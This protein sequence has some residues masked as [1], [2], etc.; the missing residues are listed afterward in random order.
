M[1]PLWTAN[2]VSTYLGVPVKTLYK[3]RSMNYGPKG[4]RVGRFLRYRPTDVEAWLDS[5]TNPD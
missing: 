2:D 1:T 4:H 3:W 5:M